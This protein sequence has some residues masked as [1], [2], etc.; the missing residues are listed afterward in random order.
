MQRILCLLVFLVLLP[1][2]EGGGVVVTSYE[3]RWPDFS[4]NLVTR[5]LQ[6][7]DARVDAMLRPLRS[8]LQFSEAAFSIPHRIWC[9]FFIR[10]PSRD[11]NDPYL[12]IDLSEAVLDPFERCSGI[13]LEVV[14]PIVDLSTYPTGFALGYVYR[15][16]LI[17]DRYRVASGSDLAFILSAI[18]SADAHRSIDEDYFSFDDEPI[19]EEWFRAETVFRPTLRIVFEGAVDFAIDVDTRNGDLVATGRDRWA[20]Y[21]S[22]AQPFQSIRNLA[23]VLGQK[24]AQPGATDNPDDAQ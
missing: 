9:P 18:S 23:K 8:R 5:E 14:E 22:E 3:I 13:R 15:G 20:A 6:C 17:V 1:T 10:V 24:A 4:S 2:A 12:P 11:S 19:D 16:S 21:R 7:A